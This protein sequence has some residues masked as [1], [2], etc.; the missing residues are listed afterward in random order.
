MEN[1][2]FKRPKDVLYIDEN[3]ESFKARLKPFNSLWGGRIDF[4]YDLVKDL[5]RDLPKR[6]SGREAFDHARATAL[7]LLDEC[8]L[9][10]AKTDKEKE[11]NARIIIGALAHDLVED[12]P[13]FGYYEGIPYS[14][15]MQTART[16][17]EPYW[18]RTVADL[19]IALTKPRVDGKDILDKDHAHDI[20]FQKLSQNPEALLIKMADR[21]HNLRDFAGLSIGERIEIVTETETKYF[22]LF[23]QARGKYPKETEYLLGQMR[24]AIRDINRSIG[25]NPHQLTWMQAN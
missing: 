24:K 25:K 13:S 19:I 1:G 15:G 18:G 5:F 23:E 2:R 10:H 8:G 9:G 14:E 12:K 6:K 3:W 22:G 16:R 4:T 20:Y 7:T 11:R 17:L 21:L